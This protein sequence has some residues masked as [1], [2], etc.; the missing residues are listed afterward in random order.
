[1]AEIRSNGSL[2]FD[3]KNEAALSDQEICR[4]RR[5]PDAIRPSLSHGQRNQ[6]AAFFTM[7]H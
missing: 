3:G 6:T 1:M 5:I 2:T 7:K 4:T